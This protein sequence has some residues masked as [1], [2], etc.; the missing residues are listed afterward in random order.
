[1]AH[2]HPIAELIQWAVK[3]SNKR[4]WPAAHDLSHP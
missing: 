1:M 4:F 3:T 2:A